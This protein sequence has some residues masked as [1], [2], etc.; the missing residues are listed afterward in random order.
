[1]RSTTATRATRK[2]VSQFDD[3]QQVSINLKIDT[4]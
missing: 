4:K 3:R 2:T 1:M